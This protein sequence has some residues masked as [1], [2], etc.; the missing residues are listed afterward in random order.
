MSLMRKK[1]FIAFSF[2]SILLIICVR[3]SEYHLSRLSVITIVH[4]YIYAGTL[5][6]LQ[7]NLSVKEDLNELHRLKINLEDL[8]ITQKIIHSTVLPTNQECLYQILFLAISC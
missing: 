5:N 2:L 7:T 6:S 4:S 1:F 3:Y 8:I